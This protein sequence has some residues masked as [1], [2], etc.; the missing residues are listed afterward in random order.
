[1]LGPVGTY[2]AHIPFEPSVFGGN[3]GEPRSA[4]RFATG[5][6]ELLNSILD[7]ERKAKALLEGAG[8]RFAWNSAIT[9]ATDLHPASIKAKIWTTGERA[10]TVRNESGEPITLPTQAWP[11]PRANALLEACGIYRAA[12]GGAGLVLQVTALQ[13]L[14]VADQVGAA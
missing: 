5:E 14:Q 7:A 4:I 11:R 8:A 13:L 10:A 12:S 2:P 1:M 9:E 3:G 6:A